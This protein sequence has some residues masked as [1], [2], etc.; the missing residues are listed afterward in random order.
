MTSVVWSIHAR[1]QFRRRVGGIVERATDEIVE[2]IDRGEAEQRR[3]GAFV[4][5]TAVADYMCAWT[6]G[7]KAAIVVTVFAPDREPEPEAA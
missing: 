7:G 3:G 5:R 2:R 1:H 4:I 6:L